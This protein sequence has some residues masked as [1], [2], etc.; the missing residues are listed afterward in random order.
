MALF[1]VYNFVFCFNQNEGSPGEN[2][3]A[4]MIGG[5][6]GALMNQPGQ[7][8]PPQSQAA[9]GSTTGSGTSGTR[10]ESIYF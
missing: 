6:V 9:S 4:D 8:M 7:F 1:N 3:F 10:G 2:A 5:L